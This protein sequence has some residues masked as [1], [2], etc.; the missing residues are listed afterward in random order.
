M[1]TLNKVCCKVSPHYVGGLRLGQNQL[2]KFF[3]G[4][5]YVSRLKLNCA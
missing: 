5:Q 2:K 1:C 3:M 4:V